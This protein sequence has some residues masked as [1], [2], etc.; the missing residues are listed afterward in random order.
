MGHREER[1][2]RRNYGWAKAMIRRSNVKRA[3]CMTP[4]EHMQDKGF[5]SGLRYAVASA[6]YSYHF[7]SDKSRYVIDP[8]P[9]RE[10]KENGFE[11]SKK[12]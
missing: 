4:A 5:R 10:E 12:A 7:D 3:A 11:G 8:Y 9:A 1:A 2:R 6:G